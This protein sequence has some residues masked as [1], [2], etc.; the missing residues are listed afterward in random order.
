[1]EKIELKLEDIKKTLEEKLPEWFAEKLS[2]SYDNPLKDAVDEAIKS[3][4]GIIKK[5]VNNIF[6]K[7]LTDENFKEEIGS[8]VITAVIQKGLRD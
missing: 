3:K 7:L 2:S 1:M 5:L 8:R 6:D 4:E